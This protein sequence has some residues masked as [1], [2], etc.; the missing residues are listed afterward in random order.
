MVQRTCIR[1]S[2]SHF[3]PQ[4]KACNNIMHFVKMN[5]D[6][7]KSN[8]GPNLSFYELGYSRILRLTLS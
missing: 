3:T 2:Y 1:L 8:L 5:L 7:E 6:L 4:I